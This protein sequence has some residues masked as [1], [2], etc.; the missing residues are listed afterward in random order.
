MPLERHLYLGVDLGTQG[1][2]AVV[3]DAQIKEVIAD[4]RAP[5]RLLESQDPRVAEQ[6]PSSWGN[7]LRDVMRDLFAV[8]GVEGSHC[9]RIA[10]SGQQHGFVPLDSKG[11]VIRPAK[12]CCDTASG[13][14]AEELISGGGGTFPSGTR[15]RKSCG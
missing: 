6:W 11:E 1:L 2:K 4:A 13:A 12:L 9:A 10:V 7:A 5:Y 8:P 14:E 15:L 3:F